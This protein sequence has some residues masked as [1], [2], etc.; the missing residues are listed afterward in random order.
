MSYFDDNEDRIVYGGRRAGKTSREKIAR[1]SLAAPP[2]SDLAKARTA[3][4]AAF[5]PLWQ[6]G[7]FARGIAYEWLAS[8][9]GLPVAKCHMILFD[10]AQCQRVVDICMA[11]PARQKAA[12]ADFE[13]L[14]A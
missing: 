11:H 6:S 2:G 12:A 1:A 7:H 3:A 10:I 8:E 13:D 14:D 4:H 5:D 9:L